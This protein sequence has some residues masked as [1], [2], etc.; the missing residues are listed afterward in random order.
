[1][2]RTGVVYGT[3]DLHLVVSKVRVSVVQRTVVTM[4]ES[5]KRC[6]FFNFFESRLLIRSFEEETE[7]RGVSSLRGVGVV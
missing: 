2:Q 3:V 1:M 7:A 6:A 4:C 5:Y